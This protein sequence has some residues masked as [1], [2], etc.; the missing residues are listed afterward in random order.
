MSNP[1]QSEFASSS[2]NNSSSANSLTVQQISDFNQNMVSAMTPAMEVP[3][4][5]LDERMDLHAN[6]LTAAVNSLSSATYN[7]L[8]KDGQNQDIRENAE[9]SDN[10]E[11]RKVDKLLTIHEDDRT[12][13]QEQKEITARAFL[14]TPSENY[15]IFPAAIKLFSD[16]SN[17]DDKK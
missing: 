1:P 17:V 2:I 12:L 11:T 10:S 5:S 13:Y 8:G 9:L 6:K 7:N 4:T 16:S 3:I 15:L 14:E